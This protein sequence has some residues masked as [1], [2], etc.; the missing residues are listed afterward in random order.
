[1]RGAA[2]PPA[3]DGGYK[4]TRCP[5]IDQGAPL[6]HTD[7]IQNFLLDQQRDQQLE[8]GPAARVTIYWHSSGL[9]RDLAASMQQRLEARGMDVTL[10]QHRDSAQPDAAFIGALVT[11]EHA[12]EVLRGLPYPIR[13]LFRQDY[14]PRHGGD[15]KGQLIGVGYVSSHSAHDADDPRTVPVQVS[16][17]DLESLIKPGLSN[18]EFQLRLHEILLRNSSEGEARTTR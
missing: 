12:R 7:E 8:S 2:P 17:G 14:P 15:D 9:T 16:V 5:N 10:L 4:A 13:Y 11:A 3:R 1:M 18:T 6:G